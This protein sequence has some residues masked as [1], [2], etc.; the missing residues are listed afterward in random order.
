MDIHTY[1]KVKLLLSPRHSRGIT[2]WIYC[3]GS[4]KPNPVRM[5]LGAVMTGP[6][7]SRHTLSQATRTRPSDD[8]AAK[9]AICPIKMRNCVIDRL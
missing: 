3:D 2:Y 1:L 4:A 8:I 9:S 6:D 5:G 7:G